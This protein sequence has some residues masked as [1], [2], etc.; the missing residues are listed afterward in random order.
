MLK[1]AS[2]PFTDNNL[3]QQLVKEGAS[4]NHFKNIIQHR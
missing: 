3:A 2:A 1:K 4:K